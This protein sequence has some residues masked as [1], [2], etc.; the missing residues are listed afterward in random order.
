MAGFRMLMDAIGLIARM[1]VWL[2]ADLIST[3]RLWVRLGLVARQ[4]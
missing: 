1:D 2:C 3:L 4:N